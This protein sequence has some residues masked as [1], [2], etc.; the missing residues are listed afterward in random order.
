MEIRM[1]V[2]KYDDVAIQ[3][4][5][6]L[7]LHTSDWRLRR[8]LKVWLA[9]WWW[10]QSVAYRHT[11][12]GTRVYMRVYTFFLPLWNQLKFQTHYNISNFQQIRREVASLWRPQSVHALMAKRLLGND[13]LHTL[14]AALNKRQTGSIQP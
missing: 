11:Y 10:Q 7:I 2:C 8:L 4:V 3:E 6:L 12:T 9:W 14:R 5:A 1:Y 13:H